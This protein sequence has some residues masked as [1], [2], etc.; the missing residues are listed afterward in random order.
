[1][2]KNHSIDWIYGN[3]KKF[4]SKD[5]VDFLLGK[6]RKEQVIR[7][8][9]NVIFP[10]LRV[11]G[12]L[13]KLP[14]ELWAMVM[15]NKNE[16]ELLGTCVFGIHEDRKAKV[17]G[18][19]IHKKF[20]KRGYGF[21]L[22]KILMSVLKKMSIQKATVDYITFWESNDHWQ[23]I[24]NQTGWS[25]P[26]LLHYYVTMPDVKIQF[27]KSWL[28]ERSIEPPYLV[29]TWNTTSFQ[30][31]KEVLHKKEWKGIVRKAL[32]PFQLAPYVVPHCSMLLKKEDVVVGWLIC[33]MLQENVVQGTTLFVHPDKAKGTGL[34]LLGEAFKRRKLGARVV[35]IVEKENAPMLN[36]INNYVIGGKAELYEKERRTLRL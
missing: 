32:D 9:E 30:Q 26:H 34:A 33:H 17:Y 3:L 24:L 14:D 22:M 29:E 19:L 12:H 16:K 8:F 2:E 6:S 7:I 11:T 25:S 31:L 1:M 35:F 36:L 20:R 15:V 23:Q 4:Y 21:S 27:G 10:S 28:T 5:P 13:E 18:F